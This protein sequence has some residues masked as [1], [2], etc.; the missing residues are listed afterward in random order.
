M[1]KPAALLGPKPA[2]A[3]VAVLGAALYND[4]ANL[5]EARDSAKAALQLV[6]FKA[7]DSLVLSQ[8]PGSGLKR[9]TGTL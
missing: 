5:K 4:Q 1:I 7:V 6:S 3:R 2:D 8:E 9:P